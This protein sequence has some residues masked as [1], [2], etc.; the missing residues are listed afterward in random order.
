MSKRTIISCKYKCIIDK[1]IIGL[2]KQYMYIEI[3]VPW[4]IFISYGNPDVFFLFAIN[5]DHESVS[6]NVVG[7]YVCRN[8]DLKTIVTSQRLWEDLRCIHVRTGQVVVSVKDLFSSV[9]FLRFGWQ[10]IRPSSVC[11]WNTIPKKLPILS[12]V[13]VFW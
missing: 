4:D 6:W 7:K 10:H 8:W 9:C 13:E 11:Y 5:S 2:N 12:I 1:N 3:H